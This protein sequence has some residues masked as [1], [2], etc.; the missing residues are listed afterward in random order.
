LFLK[1][2]YSFYR[3]TNISLGKNTKIHFP[4]TIEGGG[5]IEIG[6][7]S[8]LSKKSKI[9]VQKDSY[10]SFGN[11]LNLSENSLFIVSN[12]SSFKTGKG[13]NLGLGSRIFISN[14]SY[15]NDNNS[16]S[17]NVSIFARE[18]GFF[19]KFI[20]GSN[21][22]I[23]DNTII[24]LCNDVIIQDDVAIGPN[25]IIY[26]HDHDYKDENLPAWKGKII[27]KP[28]TIH[29]GAWVGSGVTILPG[30]TIGKRVVVAAGSVVTKSLEEN[31][32]YAGVPAKKLK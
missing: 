21:C 29:H 30:V 27:S 32:V 25:C 3:L 1:A 22:N 11:H 19:G 18:L 9:V 20:M 16:I 15:C 5:K 10:L 14:Y 2:T 17:S 31:S 7:S 26:T 28:V 13:F 6:N 12:K 23:G 4:V 24:D 8:L